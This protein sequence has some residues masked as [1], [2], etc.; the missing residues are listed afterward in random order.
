M[1]KSRKIMVTSAVERVRENGIRPAGTTV[2]PIAQ[3]APWTMYLE[4]QALY[5]MKHNYYGS[6]TESYYE[7]KYHSR[8]T[9]S[10][11]YPRYHNNQKRGVLLRAQL[12]RRKRGVLM[13]SQ[14]PSFHNNHGDER[15]RNCS[16]NND[17]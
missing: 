2:V 17:E 15:G 12:P 10:V 14:L 7:L 6:Y 5:V 1:S 8:N 11:Y 16:L 13:L 9:E 3:T 4:I